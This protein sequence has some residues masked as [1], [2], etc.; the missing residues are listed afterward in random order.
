M[1]LVTRN[2]F[3]NLI[4]GGLL[5]LLTIVITPMQINILGIEAYGIVGFISTLQISF[6]AF[7]LGLSSTVAR[8]L[9]VDIS[10]GKRDSDSLLRTAATIYW[11]VAFVIGILMAAYA[12][13]MADRW[14]GS[15]RLDS[16]VLT[17]SLQVISL[18]L[19]LRWPVSL[20]TGV[21]IGLQRMDLLNAIKLATT[22][23]RLVGGIIVLLHWPNLQAF[24]LWTSLNALF[25]VT[26]FWLTCHRAHARMPILPG[27][28][29]PALVRVWRFSANM[30]GLAIL[31]ILI[32]QGDRLMMSRLLPLDT[33]GTYSLAYNVAAII[34]AVIGAVSTAMLPALAEAYGRGS[35]VD[36]LRQYS[37]AS[38]F[39]LFAVA[40]IAGSFIFFGD[41]L[42]SVWINP[43]AAAAAVQPLVLLTLGFWG[44][45]IVSNAYQ[46]LIASG[47]PQLAL[48][49][50]FLSFLPY[51]VALYLLIVTFGANGAALAWL[52]LNLS[53]V[54]VI[55]PVAH[56]HVL[57]VSVRPYLMHSVVP[58][59]LLAAGCFGLA[60]FL[61]S[62]PTEPP[63]IV[64]DFLALAAASLAYAGIGYLL[65]GI[66]GQN[67]LK[68]TLCPRIMRGQA[69]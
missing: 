13:P 34:P 39:L 57:H 19:A 28:S 62:L 31:T 26:T 16:S 41:S 68:N 5:M 18:Y 27:F 47:R 32:V 45:A 40:P 58:F 12:G 54:L 38:R 24:L 52:L 23:I 60:R 51:I 7:D 43:Y 3:A 17:R 48:R 59:T 64:V 10:V 63:A 65:I 30:N 61:A 21:L 44:S 20:Y 69:R 22:A 11:C 25:E 50:S 42:L 6:T 46:V 29:W 14:F 36:V 9:A 67:Y 55:V 66:E 8:E 56:R 15:H 1:S 53:Y 4:G 49:V 37:N 35:K 33:L 2:I